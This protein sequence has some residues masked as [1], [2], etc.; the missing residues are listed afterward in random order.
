[1]H[2]LQNTSKSFDRITHVQL[3]YSH[4]S[5]C[6]ENEMVHVP[7]LVLVSPSNSDSFLEPMSQSESRG[8][9][10]A[11]AQEKP[12]ELLWGGWRG[13]VCILGCKLACA[14]LEQNANHHSHCPAPVGLQSVSLGVWNTPQNSW[15]VTDSDVA[16]TLSSGGSALHLDRSDRQAKHSFTNHFTS[17][18]CL[19]LN[20]CVCVYI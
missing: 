14:G 16:V 6:H 10:H 12:S 15:P 17:F 7:P 13:G 5:W 11:E 9:V 4:C 18:I 2:D 8:V 19:I 20:M 3:V 1:M